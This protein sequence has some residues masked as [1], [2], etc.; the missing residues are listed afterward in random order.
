MTGAD[1]GMQELATILNLFCERHQRP[2][3]YSCENSQSTSHGVKS[4]KS[5]QR[6]RISH[7]ACCFGLACI[8]NDTVHPT[9]SLESFEVLIFCCAAPLRAPRG[10]QNRNVGR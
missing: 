9:G 3:S 5:V 4:H 2:K 10:H 6:F 7:F 8:N 1:G